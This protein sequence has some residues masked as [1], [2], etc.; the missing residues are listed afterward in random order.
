MKTT[1]KRQTV[2]RIVRREPVSRALDVLTWLGDHPEAPWSIR[3]VAR[4]LRT[5]PTTVHRIFGVFEEHGL[6]HKDANG[7]YFP[8]L[9]LYKLARSI[10]VGQDLPVMVARTHLQALRDTYNETVMLGAYDPGRQEMMYVD[11]LESSHPVQHIVVPNRWRSIYPGAAGI[12]ILAFLPEPERRSVYARGLEAFTERTV[13]DIDE[14]E[15][16]FAK[17]RRDGYVVSRG[18]RRVGAVA[19]A[20]PVFDAVRNVFGDVVVTIPEQR[21]E[22]ETAETIGGATA[23]AAMAITSELRA[24]GF[25]RGGLQS[26]EARDASDGILRS[27]AEIGD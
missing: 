1:K 8:S 3:Q 15:K 5:S 27:S 16:L 19:I 9:G 13:V 6:V 26:T 25:V 23:T 2:E 11:V 21:F 4:N 10:V 14:L 24:A 18:Q 22:E 12:G 17:I 7:G 20:S